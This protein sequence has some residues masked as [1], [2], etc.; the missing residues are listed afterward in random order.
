MPK[1]K[2]KTT[3]KARARTA[4][5]A[6][7]PKPTPQATPEPAPVALEAPG[8][9]T[10]PT[11]SHRDRNPRPV[12]E[13]NRTATLIRGV[14]YVLSYST[15]PVVFMY[16]EAVSINENEFQRL[17]AAVD[18]VDFQDPDKVACTIRSCR[19]FIFH[20]IESGDEIPMPALPDVE[21]GPYA[22]D[23]F[24]EAAHTRKF[25]GQEFTAR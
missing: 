14:T 2:K 3:P 24:E 19:K 21:G 15:G 25:Q 23:A 10:N 12:G 20:H 1:T 13:L 6:E 16:G 4:P 5:A 7:A 17:G 22:R 18:K 9:R 11:W 8:F